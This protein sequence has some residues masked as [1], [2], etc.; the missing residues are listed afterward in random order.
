M[1][2][3]TDSAE[4]AGQSETRTRVERYDATAIEPR[5]QARWDELRMHETDLAEARNRYYL[6]TMYPLSL[7]HI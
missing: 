1:T 6:L 3:T 5:W 2:D 7:I 4:T